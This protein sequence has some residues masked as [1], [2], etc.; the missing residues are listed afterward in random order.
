MVLGSKERS[1]RRPR[2]CERSAV[3]IERV[4]SVIKRASVSFGCS[5]RQVELVAK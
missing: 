1:N 5:R 3:E 4:V 2:W